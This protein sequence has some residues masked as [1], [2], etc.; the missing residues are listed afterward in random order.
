MGTATKRE[1][2]LRDERDAYPG[3]GLDEF[4]QNL[5]ANLPKQILNIISNEGVVHDCFSVTLCIKINE[6]NRA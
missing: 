4:Q 2:Y 1:A 5:C 3:V 6:V